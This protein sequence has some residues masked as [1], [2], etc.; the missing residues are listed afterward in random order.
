MKWFLIGSLGLICSCAWGQDAASTLYNKG[1]D[2]LAAG[3]YGAAAQDFDGILNGY[4]NT[5]NIDDVRIRAGYAYLHIGQFS[6]AVDRLA[7]ETAEN[8]KPEYRGTALY[9]TALA[10]FSEGQKAAD[11]ATANTAFQQSATTFTTLVNYINTS[12]NPGNQDFLEDSIYYR[13]LAQYSRED[14]DDAEK[15]LLQLLSQFATTSL[16]LPDY[17]LLLGSLYAVETNNAVKDKKSADDIHALSDKALAAFDQVSENPNA[18]VQANDANMSKAEVLY[19]IAQLDTANTA[20]Y[21]KALDAFRLVRPKE[22]MLQIQQ[23]RLDQ[24]KKAS[25]AALANAGAGVGASLANENSRLI[26]R[27]ASRLSDLQNGPD[28]II[29]ALIR[30]GE[31][32]TTIKEPDEARTILKRLEAHATLTADQQQEVDFQLLYSY[33]Q[34]GQIDQANKALDAYLAKHATDPQVDSISYMIAAAL[35]KKK[36]FDGALQ[37]AKRSLKDFPKGRYVAEATSIEAQ[38]LTGLGRVPEAN[39]L[40]ADFLTGNQGSAVAS[41]MQFTK[42]QGEVKDGKLDDALADYK[43]VRDNTTASAELQA[44]AAV[45][46][47][48]TLLALKRDDDAISESK[49]F[50]TKNPNAA[51]LPIVLVFSAQAM[52]HKNDPAAIPAF[53]DVA[54]TYPKDPTA[55]YALFQVVQIY[56]DQKNVVAMTKAAD[57]LR[58]AFP[59][60]YNY[61]VPVADYVADADVALKNYDAAVAAYQTLVDVPKLDVAATAQNQIGSVCLSAAKD[62][63]QSIKPA[64][65]DEAEKQLEAAEAAYLDTLKKFPAQ[66]DAVGDAFQGLVDVITTRHSWGGLTDADYEAYL[67]KATADLTSPEMKTRVELAKAGLVFSEKNGFKQYPAALDRFKK[68]LA[69]NAVTLTRQEANQY[70]EL[71]LSAKDYAKAIEIYNDLLST[72][73]D[74]MYAEADAN[75][76]LGAAYL[77]QGDLDHAVSYFGD[78][79]KLPGGAAWHPH[80]FDAEYGLALAAEKA[81]DPDGSARKSYADIMRAPQAGTLLQ[82]KAMLGY[83]RLL[84]KAGASLKPATPGTIE[85]A[86]HYYQEPSILY[87]TAVAEVSAEGLF[88][89]GQAFANAGDTTDAK[90]QYNNL[91]STYQTTAPDWVAKANAE[92]AKLGP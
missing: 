65:R 38:A 76:G 20:E 46:Y 30:M 88:D 31:C 13:A 45:G 62:L 17:S 18:L 7:L 39:K 50:A 43:A 89:A 27:E 51:T 29:A 8:A 5:P 64:D 1:A 12:P 48:Q 87:S 41:Q 11:K 77:A 10:Q 6:D 36:D 14:Y 9:F 69:A 66:L 70:G 40:M 24:L 42:A 22:D 75:Y 63:F 35:I 47:I 80:I 34:G 84:E 83:G 15:D 61:L 16:K 74:N 59:T 23:A 49:D 92:L 71:L 78:M 32:Y 85:F 28:P 86:I 2:D 72:F 82:A 91:I 56:K 26:D 21:E 33:A 37:E 54:K 53:Q 52:Q 55:P 90:A 58:A 44:A 25:Q 4:P 60:A 81:G 57:D 3:N 68:A 79:V 67:T 73:S 19:L